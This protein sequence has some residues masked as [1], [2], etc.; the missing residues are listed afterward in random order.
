MCI[1]LY[2]YHLPQC[3]TQLGILKDTLTKALRRTQAQRDVLRKRCLVTLNGK[4]GLPLRLCPNGMYA[5]STRV[6]TVLAFTD[7][8]YCPPLCVVP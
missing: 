7:T 1:V 2:I 4:D 5:S 3:H 8:P 6:L